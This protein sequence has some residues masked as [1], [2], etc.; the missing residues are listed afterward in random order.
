MGRRL[1]W[2]SDG[3]GGGTG[4]PSQAAKA[5]ERPLDRGSLPGCGGLTAESLAL[6][7]ERD[8]P[9]GLGILQ[10]DPRPRGEFAGGLPRKG[11]GPAPRRQP[12]QPAVVGREVARRAPASTL[13]PPAPQDEGRPEG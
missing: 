13:R 11:T 4:W 12:E 6:V 5:D 2:E 9:D 10:D 8:H 3:P 1:R 7:Q